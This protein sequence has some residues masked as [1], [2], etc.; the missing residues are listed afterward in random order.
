[1]M[2]VSSSNYLYHMHILEL[3]IFNSDQYLFKSNYAELMFYVGINSVD[4]L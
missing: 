3:Q 1:M 2:H 4:R